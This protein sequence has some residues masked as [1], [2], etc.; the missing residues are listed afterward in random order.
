ML[1]AERQPLRQ[2]ARRPL[3]RA[4]GGEVGW[5]ESC[6]QARRLVGDSVRRHDEHQPLAAQWWQGVQLLA[7]TRHQGGATVDEKGHVRP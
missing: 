2:S 4:A 6:V 5:L 3:G 7:A 1:F